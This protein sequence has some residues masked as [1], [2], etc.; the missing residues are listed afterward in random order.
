[1]GKGSIR[2]AWKTPRVGRL[3]CAAL[4]E[5]SRPLCRPDCP[6]PPGNRRRPVPE[7]PSPAA[8]R[9]HFDRLA[10]RTAV[11]KATFALP[12]R[13]IPVSNRP[14]RRQGDVPR[15]RR[16]IFARHGTGRQR[17]LGILALAAYR[18]LPVWCWPR[19]IAVRLVSVRRLST[20]TGTAPC[21]KPASVRDRVGGKAEC[22]PAA[23][24]THGSSIS[25]AL[26]C[27]P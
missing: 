21:R 16:P 17:C 26:F 8:A 18:R 7:A 1:M 15:A 25:P 27:A 9:H 23:G 10:G 2:A 24:G 20:A 13:L 11:S 19:E 6:T 22:Q 12:G 14:A 4:G 3:R 5:L